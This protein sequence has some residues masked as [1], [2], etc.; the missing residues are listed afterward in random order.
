MRELSDKEQKRL[1][2]KEKREKLN[3]TEK[4]KL[5]D[6]V[7]K[8]FLSLNEY[9]YSDTILLY[10]SKNKEINTSG[11]MKKAFLDAKKVAAPRCINKNGNMEF[12]YINCF[13]NLAK[14]IFGIQEPKHNCVK[15]NKFDSCLCAVPGYSFD[16]NGYRLGYGKGF[17]DRFLEDFNGI[18]VGLC[19]EENI[20]KALPF[21]KFDK[22]VD[23][24]V[25]EKSIRFINK[26][27]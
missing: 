16:I 19:Y 20:E 26:E 23:I 15:L 1:F 25:T 4:Q 9:L 21:C 7:I 3:T 22:R 27:E 12:Y 2:Y 14:G 18:S 6:M 5:D 17:Y 11:I 13:S 8:N 24:I 10:I